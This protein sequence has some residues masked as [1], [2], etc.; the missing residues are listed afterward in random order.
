[1]NKHRD[2][3]TKQD[4]YNAL[5]KDSGSVHDPRNA[6]Q[7]NLDMELLTRLRGELPSSR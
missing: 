4:A 7:N 1:M 5:A 2:R 3:R 6:V